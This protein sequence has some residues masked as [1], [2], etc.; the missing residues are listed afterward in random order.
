MDPHVLAAIEKSAGSDPAIPTLLME[1]GVVPSLCTVTVCAALD[2]FT[3]RDPKARL[4]GDTLNELIFPVAVPVSGTLM[5]ELAPEWLKVRVAARLPAALGVKVIVTVQ[6]EEPARLAPHVLAEIAKSAAL[7]PETMMLL[8]AI[9][10]VPRFV[11]ATDWGVPLE[12][13]AT[14]PHARALG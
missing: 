14:S 6:L 13:R 11:R 7:V 4:C 3:S 2:E 5:E 12:P 9:R 8:I 10:D 1:I